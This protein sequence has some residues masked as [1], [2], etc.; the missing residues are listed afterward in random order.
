MKLRF[1][2]CIFPL[3]LFVTLLLHSHSPPFFLACT[4]FLS[5][6]LLSMPVTTSLFVSLVAFYFI[7]APSFFCLI[8]AV[9]GIVS[10]VLCS[11]KHARR[12]LLLRLEHT[13]ASFCLFCFFFLSFAN[14]I[15]RDF[16]IVIFHVGFS[17]FVI[18]A[19]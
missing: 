5:S 8:L 4:Y 17:P 1:Y 9:P 15:L 18:L 7:Q 3:L 12:L 11:S 2:I 13:Q 14:I 19:A 6:F 16:M 10:C